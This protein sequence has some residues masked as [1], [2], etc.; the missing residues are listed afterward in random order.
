MKWSKRD[1]SS[2]IADVFMRNVGI[3]SLDEVNDWYRKYN[4]NA[5]RIDG[6]DKAVEII[7]KFKSSPITI[8][9]DFDADGITST[10]ILRLALKDFG[11]SNVKYRIPKRFSEGFGIS[12]RIID[13]IESGLVIT[14]DN[15]IAQPDVIKKAKDKGLTV[16][17]TDHHQPLVVDGKVVLPEAD[18][19]IDPNA[20]PGSADFNGYCGAGIAYKLAVEMNGKA[21]SLRYLSLAG[22][23]TVADVM[24]LREENYVFVRTAL[25]NLTSFGGTTVGAYALV[26][27][28]NLTR[29]I[30]S[31]D[32]GFK[33]GPCINAASRM[34]DDGAKDVVELLTYNGSFESA[35]PLAETLI[36]T[37]DRRKEAKKEGVRIAEK[38]ISDECMYG[39][40]PLIVNVPGV[41][42]GIIGIIAGYL[43]EKY[44][45][46][47]IVVSE[48]G[49]VLKGSA[50]S[51]PGYN[52]KEML[53]KCADTLVAYGGHEGA[54]GL[55]ISKDG[56]DAFRNKIQSLDESINFVPESIEE[57]YYD[58]EIPAKDIEKT[59]AELEKYG[60]YG[61]G[62]PEIVF[63]VTG[64]ST[65]PQYGSFSKTMG[66]G[67]IVKMFGK[68][69]SAL[70]FDA[71][72]KLKNMKEPK[73][74]T[75][76]G[77]LSDNYFGGSVE[78][79]VEVSEAV[80]EAV[81][82]VETPLASRLKAMC[83]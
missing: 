59:I 8:V 55:T 81:A 12:E 70:C 36:S 3:S 50:R 4:A 56:L 33:I 77:V 54:A 72:D 40:T 37:N 66:D 76:Y 47:A 58:L 30:T 46:P 65:V 48:I 62:N 14:V 39:D 80:E 51:C 71:P 29:H 7:S 18:V 49:G 10:S 23:G 53:D 73:K 2:S 16:I 13:E 9:G 61:E 68:G 27:A 21:A 38:V 82:K 67:S 19:V 78:H 69:M 63:K 35:I 42:H 5:Y 15:G 32:V 17:V 26:S 83:S 6:L 24:T 79:Q 44:K 60:P 75:L 41:E 28:L 11:C 45:V 31:K 43:C 64:F 34:S 25:K 1:T 22:I 20:I 74:F 52:I 57:G